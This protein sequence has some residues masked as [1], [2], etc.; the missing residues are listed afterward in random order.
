VRSSARFAGNDGE[1][2]A[3]TYE[4]QSR[5]FADRA[6]GLWMGAEN[7]LQKR[8]AGHESIEIQQRFPI[9]LWGLRI[10]LHHDGTRTTI[11]ESRGDT[12]LS[13]ADVL[14]SAD[15]KE[16]AV[17]ICGNPP[18]RMA[19]SLSKNRSLPF[20]RMRSDVAGHIQAD[21][22]LVTNKMSV[23][24]TFLWACTEGKEAFLRRYPEAAVR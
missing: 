1:N 24:E 6:S 17:F 19:Y 12:F 13:F 20:G 15:N 2:N 21:Y 22:H 5:R 16:L 7:S 3:S 10:L 4:H 8:P 9:N 18:L 23:D 11:F 14:W